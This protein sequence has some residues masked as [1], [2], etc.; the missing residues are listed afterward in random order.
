MPW[1]ARIDD[2]ILPPPFSVQ[3]EKMGLKRLTVPP[4]P[5]Y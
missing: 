2:A 5:G 3:A 4:V 1:S